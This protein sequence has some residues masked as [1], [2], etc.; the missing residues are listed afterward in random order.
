LDGGILLKVKAILFDLDGT[1]I[2]SINAYYLSFIKGI[3]Q[4]R[5]P[6]PPR[7]QIV[8]LLNLGI[9][10]KEILNKILLSDVHDRE[11]VI[12]C[13]YQE[14]KSAYFTYYSKQIR[15]IQRVAE[16]LTI[17]SNKGILMGIITGRMSP[18]DR[19][20]QNLRS[21]GIDKFIDVVVTGLEVQRRKPAPDQIIVCAKLLGVGVDE[22]LVVGD[23]VSDMR[24][25]K[26]AGAKTAA[27]LTGV[28][29]FNSFLEENPDLILSGIE[30]LIL[31]FSDSN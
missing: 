5:Q 2:D 4:L 31:V 16:T 28:G 14:I 20:R 26:A 22:C 12:N 18:I 30:E 19:L 23:S 8:K 10:L 11:S 25:G 9:P 24:A 13:C 3:S 17:L 7:D 1:L 6:L 29:T 27:V 15:L 21:Y